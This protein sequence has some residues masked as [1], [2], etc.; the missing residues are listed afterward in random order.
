MFHEYMLSILA[1]DHPSSERVR[2]YAI[3]VSNNHVNCCA[4]TLNA[5]WSSKVLRIM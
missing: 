4:L 2:W 3:E 1:L 5:S